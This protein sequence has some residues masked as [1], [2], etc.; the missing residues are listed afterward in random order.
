ME[1]DGYYGH[2]NPR[3]GHY[4]LNG[5]NPTSGADPNEVG[6][7]AYYAPGT[8]PEPNYDIEDA[9]SLGFNQSPNGA[10]EYTG[11]A[12]GSNLKGALLF[13]QFSSGD[14]VR[15][16]QLDENGDIRGDDV[17]RR[18]DGSVIDSYIDPLDII[19]NPVT[20]QLYLMTLNRGTGESKLVLLTPAPGGT[21]TDLSADENGDLG[22]LCDRRHGSVRR[23]CSR[24]PASTTTSSRSR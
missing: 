13:V 1:E 8:L 2:P 6:G 24:S 21:V 20:G 4:I 9:Y 15:M 19:Q 3:Q 11:D 5:G 23:W 14:N 12:F 16:V 10:I 22:D 17:L 18:P 7:N